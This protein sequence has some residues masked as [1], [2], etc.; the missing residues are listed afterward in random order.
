M[1]TVLV[2]LALAACGE[3]DPA[4]TAAPEAP[5]AAVTPA[6]A[7]AE[8]AASEATP[9][10]VAPAFSLTD[11]DGNT[12]NLADYA[13]KVVVL[14]W[15]NPGCPFVVSAHGE[16]PL[17]DMATKWVDKEVVWLAV[18]SGAPGK[19]GHGVDVNRSA[20][21]TWSMTHPI[22]LDESG[23]VGQA[24]GA[25]TTPQM[26]V[27]AP[28]GTIAYEGALDNAPMGEVKGGGEHVA[29]T[30]NA[31]GLTVDGKP[32]KPARTAP[33]GCSVKYAS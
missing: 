18:N 7:S 4:A 3:S 19:Q 9:A 16:G 11:L 26:V 10:S 12:H 15:F 8:V 2:L 32:A 29:Y 28:D 1:R 22:L 17:A 27:I 31:L 5:A 20:A 13:G 14:E 33:W 30:H 23:A 21:E 24:Y 6:T 25:K